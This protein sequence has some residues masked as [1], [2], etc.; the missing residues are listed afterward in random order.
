M[1]EDFFQ[2][3]V[4]NSPYKYPSRHWELDESG[5]PTQRIIDS[6]RSAEF[7]TPIPKPRKSKHAEKQQQI[8][9]DE[10]KGLSTEEQQYDLTPSQESGL[11]PPE[12][13]QRGRQFVVTVWR[14]WLTDARMDELGLNDRQKKGVVYIKQNGAISNREYQ[15][16]TKVIVR[17]AA[18]DLRKLVE[19]GLVKQVGV[20]GRSTHY[21]L[22]RKQDNTTEERSF[23]IFSKQD[24]NRTPDSNATEPTD[25]KWLELSL[26]HNGHRT[27]KT[28]HSQN[29]IGSC[30]SFS[31]DGKQD[32]Y[33]S[34]E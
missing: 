2:K 6:R 3:P 16:I 22:D 9:F 10:G 19:C 12:F 1:Q 29:H 33:D 11:P 17:T 32:A 34:Q 23:M 30:F 27:M 21:I 28:G 14:D 8:I 7:I 24:T 31:A 13:E 20:T 18:R 5:Q 26:L 4:L 15:D 25:H